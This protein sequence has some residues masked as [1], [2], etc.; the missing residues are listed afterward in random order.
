MNILLTWVLFML[1]FLALGHIL[2]ARNRS[3]TRREDESPE[4]QPIGAETLANFQQR[5][6]P[7]LAVAGHQTRDGG[8]LFEGKLRTDPQNALSQL[9]R[10]FAPDK[11]TPILQEGEHAG[12]VK[13]ALL[14]GISELAGQPAA[15]ERPRWGLHWLLFVLTLIT[16]TWAGALHAGVNLIKEP[17]RIGVGLPYSFGL[18]LILGAHELGHYFAAKRHGIRVTPPY[19]IPVPF[20]LGTFGAFIKLK[21]LAPDRR[22][23]FDVAV[24]GPL[25]GLI[26]AI[27]ALL[28][29]LQ[30]SRVVAGNASAD[31]LHTGVQVGSSFLLAILAKVALGVD[32]IEGHQLMLHPLAFAGWLGLFVTALNLLPIGQLDGGHMAHA[33]FGAKRGHAISVGALMTLFALAL[34]VWPG[35][36][37]W[38]LI[39]WFI[40]GTRD[41][42][43]LNDVTPLDPGRRALGWFAFLLLAAIMIP[44]P[45]A[46]YPSFGIHCPY[47]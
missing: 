39:V 44:V 1:L 8:V 5:V 33:L 40:A 10:A 19:F 37:M 28:I 15:A 30:Y 21:S 16:T 29:G 6:L 17:S 38:A 43:P 32:T 27:P 4:N 36:M 35:L 42:P 3:A 11:L 23:S 41:A 22:A 13:V 24:A 12:Q 26:F 47:L 45:H 20:A 18:M 46:L 7:V 2:G 9:T 25:A 31:M 14:P 34:F